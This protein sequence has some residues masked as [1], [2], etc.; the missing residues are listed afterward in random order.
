MS[1]PNVFLFLYQPHWKSFDF[2]FIWQKV[3]IR[4]KASSRRILFSNLIPRIFFSLADSTWLYS[5]EASSI[6][7][8]LPRRKFIFWFFEWK[9][10]FCALRISS[11]RDT[12]ACEHSMES[13]SSDLWFCSL[14]VGFLSKVSSS[15]K[16]CI[17]PTFVLQPPWH[18]RQISTGSSTRCSSS[19]I[20][21]SVRSLSSNRW[22][23]TLIKNICSSWR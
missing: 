13:F 4:C 20:S 23:R 16:F 18:H 21:S 3:D 11:E 22:G 17:S 14:N 10:L 2:A 15:L 9:E 7:F 8:T 19:V 6:L 12:S 5:S 1:L